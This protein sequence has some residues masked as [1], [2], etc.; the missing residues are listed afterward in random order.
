MEN[1]QEGL[2]D[3]GMTRKGKT[4][5]WIGGEGRL[6]EKPEDGSRERG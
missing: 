4:G 1:K 2:R 6:R 5:A 3:F